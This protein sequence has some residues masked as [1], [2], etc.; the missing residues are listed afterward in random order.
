MKITVWSVLTGKLSGHLVMNIPATH[1]VRKVLDTYCSY[2]GVS[3][4]SGYVMRSRDNLILDPKKTLKQANIQDGDTLSIEHLDDE[5]QTFSFG[6]W[7]MVT[8]TALLIG[9]VGLGVALWVF[10]IPL[11]G[12]Q[13]FGMVIDAGSSH[14]EVF[15]FT[16][17][18]EKPLGTADVKLLHSCFVSG[19]ISSFVTH[20][21]DLGKY[22]A[23]CLAETEV[24][25]PYFHRSSTP[26]YVGATAGMRIL[27]D[28][29]PEG[30]SA[31][32]ATLREFLVTNT[33]FHVDQKNTEIL[34]GE[35]E[36]LSGWIAVNYL[37]NLLKQSDLATV[38]ALDI[39]GASMQFT[40]ELTQDDGWRTANL[41]LFSQTYKVHSQSFLCY[42]IGQAQHRYEF[43]L[44]N[45]NTTNIKE[46]EISPLIVT[47]DPCL[48]KGV[49][50]EIAP[51]DISSPCTLTDNSKP[52]SL[53]MS[54]VNHSKLK[55]FFKYYHRHSTSETADQRAITSITDSEKGTSREEEDSQMPRSIP[56]QGSSDAPKCEEKIT[57]LFDYQFCKKTFTYGDCMGAQSVPATNGTLIAFSG[58][59]HHIM[60]LLDLRQGT[61]LEQYKKKVFNVCSL[62]AE[63]LYAAYPGLDK[64]IVEDLCFDAMFAYNLFTVGL[65]IDNSTWANVQFTD[66]VNNMEVV[67]PQGFMLNRTT[68]FALETPDPPL[69]ISSFILLIL[70][71]VAF[72]VSGVLFFRHSV[73][74]QRRSA[75]YQRCELHQ[76]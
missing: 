55:K 35:V 68:G 41:T 38:A 56:L 30:V 12:P 51:R 74:I 63:S 8:C 72:V 62:D 26:V 45:E 37:L 7:W 6:S 46:V 57:Q 4:A 44:I 36:G 70:L 3:V 66:E 39:G 31:V 29:D 24:H 43:L 28:F 60:L 10:L 27:R 5:E 32:L 73:K 11:T 16:W 14:S 47:V 33:T 67:W 2:K 42:G 52:A 40:M 69:T 76:A 64:E 65:G 19:G 34:P 71:F 50:H 54:D 22:F 25:V 15:V 58:L 9:T 61:T 59:F 1:T 17:N 13:K 20:P 75:S 18:G 48:A 21:D 53:G 49:T 23:R